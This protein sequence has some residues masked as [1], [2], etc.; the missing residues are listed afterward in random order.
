KPRRTRVVVQLLVIAIVAGAL[1]TG[2]LLALEMFAPRTQ[3]PFDLVHR[4]YP[5]LGFSLSRPSGWHETVRADT[6]TIMQPDNLRGIRVVTERKTLA[7]AHVAITA[8]I[9]K[10][11]RGVDPIALS[12]AIG[13]DSQPAFKYT[14]LQGAKYVQQWWIARPGGTFLFEFSAPGTSQG[15]AAILA[16]QIVDTFTLG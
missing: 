1:V 7:A 3:A 12:D 14:Y 13:I 4:S 2:G 9:R 10:P 8:Q 15:D 16:E 5:A 6:V 11:P